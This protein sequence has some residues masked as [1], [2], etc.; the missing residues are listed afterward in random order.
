MADFIIDG[1]QGTACQTLTCE[2]ALRA[3]AAMAAVLKNGEEP[4]V[5][6]IGRD[7]R[8]SSVI[9]EHAVIAGASSAGACVKL[10]GE[11][12]AAAV[13]FLIRKYKAAGG[14]IISSASHNNEHNGIRFLGGDGLLLDSI[15]AAEIESLIKAPEAEIFCF[16]E[17][18]G[19][20]QEEPNALWDY[21]RGRLK[22]VEGDLRGIRIAADCASGTAF[23]SAEKLF[24]GL[25]ATCYMMNEKASGESNM[26][27]LIGMVQEKLCQ[28][29]VS[30][31][32][33]GGRFLTLD[34]TGKVLDGDKIFALLARFM[35]QK[36]VLADNTIVASEVCSLGF[37]EFCRREDIKVI[38]VPAEE[39]AYAVRENGCTLG[40][41]HFGGIY[42]AGESPLPDGQLAVLRLLELLKESGKRLSLLA[43]EIDSY[44]Q[45]V[46]RVKANDEVKASWRDD[47]EI[48]KTI[49]ECRAALGG[50]GRV[51]VSEL[52]GEDAIRISAEGI[53]FERLNE[54][55][56]KIADLFKL[57]F[58]KSVSEKE[59]TDI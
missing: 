4:P 45:V 30:F 44:P 36:G 26:L 18:L 16:G 49:E 40:G 55:A 12:P 19:W 47:E 38:S 23:S 20:I 13:P 35:K 15:H 27:P 50:E 21:I 31:D 48:I 59:G 11:L 17:K 39:I 7:K 56:M 24:G 33:E 53:Q 51:S 32:L 1:L 6:C 10:L 43:D 41:D 28:L 54:L 52:Y 14:I 58:R 29:G 34:E 42:F 25:G 3:G 57:R 5:I 2:Q 22:L 37:F 8:S 9:L 46:V